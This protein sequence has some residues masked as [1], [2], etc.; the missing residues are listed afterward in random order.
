MFIKVHMNDFTHRHIIGLRNFHQTINLGFF[1]FFLNFILLY[2]Y[3]KSTQIFQIFLMLQLP[4]ILP[5]ILFFF[6][7]SF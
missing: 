4:N 1:F 6:S 3:F 5:S 7:K 2:F